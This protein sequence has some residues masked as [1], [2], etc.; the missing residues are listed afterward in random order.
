MHSSR[1]DPDANRARSPLRRARRVARVSRARAF[2]RRRRSGVCRGR[3]RFC[4]RRVGGR[5][6]PLC[7]LPALHASVA[8][9]RRSQSHHCGRRARSS[10]QRM[11]SPGERRRSSALRA[12]RRARRRAAGR[13]LRRR[14]CGRVSRYVGHRSRHA[15]AVGAGL[16]PHATPAA[17]GI[18][19]RNHSAW[20]RGNR[21]GIALRRMHCVVGRRCAALE[22]RARRHRRSA[23]SI[24]FWARAF[25]RCGGVLSAKPNAKPD[26]IVAAQPRCCDAA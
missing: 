2:G 23:A 24:R 25:R 11:A 4:K 22:R 10:A 9:R 7:L 19:R 15:L 5:I 6:D 20:N 13:R 8:D 21:G 26:A 1:R 16:D 3:R 14:L 17:S 12:R 18:I